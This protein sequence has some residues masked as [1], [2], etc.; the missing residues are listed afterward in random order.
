MLARVAVAFSFLLIAC[1]QDGPEAGLAGSS[2]SLAQE[3]PD[4]ARVHAR[5]METLA[6]DN[7]W[8][9]ARYLEFDWATATGTVRSHRWDRWEG[10]ARVEAQVDG[11]TM[12]ARFN[13]NDPSVGRV[14]LGGAEL[15]GEEAENRLAGAY[16]SHINDAYWLLMPY[17][18]TDPGVVLRYI[19][20][21]EGEEGQPWEVVELSFEDGTGLTPQ[22]V[23]HAFVNMET[24]LMD[25]WYHFSNSEAAPSPSDWTDWRQVG[26]IQLAEHRRTD[27]EVRLT[28]PHLRVETEVPEGAFEDR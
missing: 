7:G 4:V 1:G 6:P 17:K 5:M 11:E 24:G 13:A 10:E 9:R 16:R 18:W 3:D 26:P 23:Y 19:G 2:P 14:W 28:F 12:I 22:N 25:R 27:G 8:E 15:E 21:S 20:E